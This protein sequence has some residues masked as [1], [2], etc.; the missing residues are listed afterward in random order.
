MH[1]SQFSC[2][3][4]KAICSLPLV[5]KLVRVS[6]P[7]LW[8]GTSTPHIHKIVKSSNDNLTHDNHQNNNILRQ[9]AIDW[10]LF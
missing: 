7:L 5:R 6:L 1:I 3:N 2:K 9:H 4:L 10:S 8:F